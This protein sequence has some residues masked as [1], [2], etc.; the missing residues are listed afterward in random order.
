[1][2]SVCFQSHCQVKPLNFY[3][4]KE[5]GHTIEWYKIQKKFENTTADVLLLFDCCFAAQAG[6]GRLNLP[7]RV[8]LLAASA[9]DVW[10]HSPGPHSFTNALITSIKAS[11]E[12]TGKAVISEIHKT[13]C[14]EE[15]KLVAT[16]V[17]IKLRHNKSDR[18]ILLQPLGGKQRFEELS[19]SGSSMKLLIRTSTSWENEVIDTFLEWLGSD[20]PSSVV[21]MHVEEIL[22]STPDTRCVIE[23]TKSLNMS[24]NVLSDPLRTDLTSEWTQARDQLENSR[25]EPQDDGDV[26]V[27]SRRISNLGTIVRQVTALPG[28][29]ILGAYQEFFKHAVADQKILDSLLLRIERLPKSLGEQLSL[30][31][32]AHCSDRSMLPEPDA[33]VTGE[34]S[35]QGLYLERK[36]Y[37]RNMDGR[38]ID[39]AKLRAGRLAELLHMTKGQQFRCFKCVRWYQ[40]PSEYRFTLVFAKPPNFTG[41]EWVTT[42]LHEVIKK[43]MGPNRPTLNQR[44]GMALQI[45]NALQQWHQVN[46]VHQS[47]SSHNVVLFR[48]NQ[49]QAID[50]H[51]RDVDYTATFMQGFDFARPNQDPSLGKDV[52]DPERDVYK[53]PARQGPARKGHRKIHDLYSLGVV[54]LEV[55]L[56]EC[57]TSIVRLRSG[58]DIAV[59]TVQKRLLAA[60]AERLS[61]HAGSSFTEAVT[62]CLT[63]R[64]DVKLDDE[65]ESELGKAVQ[66]LVID[67]LVPPAVTE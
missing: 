30:Y 52:E 15:Y 22:Q 10:T 25:I 2:G 29:I 8:E 18:D 24:Q 34:A 41:N 55:G 53:H 51:F 27:S 44:F 43:T 61:H 11:V 20:T 39:E 67:R 60:A 23:E 21:A 65:I 33:I 19:E 12:T 7:N 38:D 50:Q 46:W 47:I 62:T 48:R 56:W 6:R 4:L 37:N 58:K 31:W 57:A 35:I 49:D 14:T 3:S 28:R 64:F 9:M 32:A 16:P 1:V 42:N 40:E 45:A 5:G 63:G 17:L 13:L 26:D 54:L 36:A 66:K 59:S